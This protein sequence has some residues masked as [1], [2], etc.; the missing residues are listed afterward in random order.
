MAPPGTSLLCS[1]LF[2]PH[3]EEVRDLPALCALAAADAIEEV[4]GLAVALKWPND[5][6]VVR[7]GEWRKLGGLLAET[8]VS[9]G[10]VEFV[11][12]GIGINVNVPPDVLPDLSPEATSI[13]AETGRE[14]D[15]ERLLDAFLTGVDLRYRRLRAGHRPF[16]EWASRL[17]TLGQEVRLLTPEGEW[18]GIA[19]A[20]DEEGALL[21]RT[22]GGEVRRVMAGD[23]WRAH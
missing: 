14:T 20:V 4:A 16:A 5:L 23:V 22:P 3:P 8:E 6:I 21:V 19:E 10:R 18:R 7:E 2:R 9:G 1:L 11:V 13:L 17:A 15:R 12:L